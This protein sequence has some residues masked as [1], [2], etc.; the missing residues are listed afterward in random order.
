MLI[1]RKNLDK[2]LKDM[3]EKMQKNFH[4]VEEHKNKKSFKV[5]YEARLLK[6]TIMYTYTQAI[7]NCCR[8]GKTYYKLSATQKTRHFEPQDD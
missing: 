7:I 1:Y 5:G 2:H 8:F 6:R 3:K 4:A